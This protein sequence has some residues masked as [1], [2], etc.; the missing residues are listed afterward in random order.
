MEIWKGMLG[1]KQAGKLAK[2][3][4]EKHLRKYGYV[5]CACTPALWTH[6]TLPINFTLSVDDFDVKYIGKTRPIK[7]STH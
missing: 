7:F 1:L 6:V 2:E 5:P 3:R 4:L